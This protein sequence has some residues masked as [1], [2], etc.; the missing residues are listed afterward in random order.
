MV[1][2]KSMTTQS[3]G[4]QAFSY[5]NTW[6][7]ILRGNLAISK[8]IITLYPSIQQIYFRGIYPDIPPIIQKYTCKSY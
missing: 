7:S 3:V 2:M 4:I 6:H 8:K 1:T 5:T